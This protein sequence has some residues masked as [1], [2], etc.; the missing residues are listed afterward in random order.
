MRTY[1]TYAFEEF[2]DSQLKIGAKITF[3]VKIATP[4]C[5]RKYIYYGPASMGLMSSRSSRTRN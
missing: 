5:I 4:L 1:G 3:L 2:Q